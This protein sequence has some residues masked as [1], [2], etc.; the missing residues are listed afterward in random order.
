MKRTKRRVWEGSDY[1][2]EGG[3]EVLDVM[4]AKMTDAQLIGF[5]LG[6]V[7]KYALRFNFIEKEEAVKDM[8]KCAHYCNLIIKELEGE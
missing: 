5:H 3:L 7:I 1:Y 6:N 2:R 8:K 4:R